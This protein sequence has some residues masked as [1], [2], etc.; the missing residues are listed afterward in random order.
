MIRP[1]FCWERILEFVKAINSAV[2]QSRRVGSTGP[3]RVVQKSSRVGAKLHR[4]VSPCQLRLFKYTT[5]AD[6]EVWQTILSRVPTQ[7]DGNRYN[8]G[9][10][11]LFLTLCIVYQSQSQLNGKFLCL[12]KIN[13]LKPPP[14]KIL[15]NPIK[16]ERGLLIAWH[17]CNCYRPSATPRLRHF[18]NTL[19]VDLSQR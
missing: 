5:S 13:M 7:H 8:V 15:H 2:V 14:D 19:H 10:M 1:G 12:T 4:N 18:F 6:L 16:L 3:D 9:R 11:L 17:V